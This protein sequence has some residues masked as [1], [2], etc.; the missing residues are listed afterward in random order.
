MQMKKRL[1]LQVLPLN[2]DKRG[3]GWVVKRINPSGK[4]LTLA[5]YYYRWG[6]NKRTAV[7]GAVNFAKKH[8]PSQVLIHGRDGKIKSER[9]YGADSPRRKG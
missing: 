4:A 5:C 8:Q 3:K 6:E 9:S 1:I 7:Q 2:D